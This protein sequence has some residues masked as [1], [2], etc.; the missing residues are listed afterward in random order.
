MGDE[1]NRRTAAKA[2]AGHDSGRRVN[3]DPDSFVVDRQGPE[4]YHAVRQEHIEGTTE[5]AE[6]LRHVRDLI[7]VYLARAKLMR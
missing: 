5:Q 6:A 2:S 3:F 4:G 7:R 1:A